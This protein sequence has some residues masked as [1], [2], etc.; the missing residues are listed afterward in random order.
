[1]RLNISE[2]FGVGDENRISGTDLSTRRQPLQWTCASAPWSCVIS[3]NLLATKGVKASFSFYIGVCWTPVCHGASV[4]AQKT[5]LLSFSVSIRPV[6][7]M[8]D[9]QIT[10]LPVI[11][12][13]TEILGDHA[14]LQCAMFMSSLMISWAWPNTSQVCTHQGKTKWVQRWK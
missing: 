7:I 8:L 12:Q 13:W 9:V 1:M 14:V 5:T 10:R 11:S 3:M 4:H 2:R 6:S